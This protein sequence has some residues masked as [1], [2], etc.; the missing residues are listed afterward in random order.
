ERTIIEKI[1]GW[2][3]QFGLTDSFAVF[4]DA[5]REKVARKWGAQVLSRLDEYVLEREAAASEVIDQWLATFPQ[6]HPDLRL[7]FY[8]MLPEKY[9]RPFSDLLTETLRAMP[10]EASGGLPFHATVQDE[11]KE[12]AQRQENGHTDYKYLLFNAD[13]AMVALTIL[14]I[15]LKNP[16]NAFQL[17]TGVTADFRR[18]GLA[19]WLKAAMFRKLAADFPSNQKITTSMRALNKPMQ[20]IND[21]MGFQLVRHGFEF[22][23]TGEMIASYLRSEG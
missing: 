5:H 22:K 8:Q 18:Q 4:N 17:M 16:D 12:E 19:K 20:A 23:L 14:G 13:D 7:E 11:N 3:D 9:V 15:D 1:G 6:N 21:A 2:M 10:E